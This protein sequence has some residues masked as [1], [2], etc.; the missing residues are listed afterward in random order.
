MLESLRARTLV[1]IANSEKYLLLPENRSDREIVESMFIEGAPVAYINQNT[2]RM[3]QERR[4]VKPR[5]VSSVQSAVRANNGP[6][7]PLRSR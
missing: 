4:R 7:R 3:W 2:F 1:W 5:V 6:L